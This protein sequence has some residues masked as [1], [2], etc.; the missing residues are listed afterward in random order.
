LNLDPANVLT[1]LPDGADALEEIQTINNNIA[2]SSSETNS[3]RQACKLAHITEGVKRLGFA[4][5]G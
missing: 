3:T 5:T 4:H 2:L 1:I